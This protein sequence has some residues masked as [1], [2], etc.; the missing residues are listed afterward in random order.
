[1]GARLAR[2]WACLSRR[3]WQPKNTREPTPEYKHILKA[4]GLPEET[5][6]HDLRHTAATRAGELGMEEYVISAMLGHGKKNVTRRYAQ[7]MAAQMRPAILNAERLYLEESAKK[8][9]NS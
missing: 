7:A 1:M 2:A 9:S 6:L 8:A 3:E 4:I 5:R